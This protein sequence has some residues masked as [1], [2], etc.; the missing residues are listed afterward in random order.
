M[1]EKSREINPKKE[2]RDKLAA[3]KEHYTLRSYLG[4]FNYYELVP[5]HHKTSLYDWKDH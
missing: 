5:T 4:V 3:T 1:L 2:S